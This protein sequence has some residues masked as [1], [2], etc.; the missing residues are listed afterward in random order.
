MCQRKL[1]FIIIFNVSYFLKAFIRYFFLYLYKKEYIL[2]N[3]LIIY[4]IVFINTYI[5]KIL[6]YF[7]YNYFNSNINQFI[8]KLCVQDNTFNKNKLILYFYNL[9]NYFKNHN[10]L[11]KLLN[12]NYYTYIIT[13]ILLQLHKYDLFY[14]V[15]ESFIKWV[16]LGSW[17]FFVSLFARKQYQEFKYKYDFNFKN[18]YKYRFKY[19]QSESYN[20]FWKA[21][22][23]YK[24]NYYNYKSHLYLKKFLALNQHLNQNVIGM[25]DFKLNK[26]ILKL[27]LYYNHLNMN[28]MYNYD[29]KKEDYTYML[30]NIFLKKKL[31]SPF[32]NETIP[33]TFYY[34]ANGIDKVKLE[35]LSYLMAFEYLYEY[36]FTKKRKSVLSNLTEVE[37][38]ENYKNFYKETIKKNFEND[39]MDVFNIEGSEPYIT[40]PRPYKKFENAIDYEN[41]FKDIN[42]FNIETLKDVILKSFKYIEE[43]EIMFSINSDLVKNLLKNQKEFD[44]LNLDKDININDYNEVKDDFN[45][46]VWLNKNALNDSSFNAFLMDLKYLSSNVTSNVLDVDLFSEP[47]LSDSNMLDLFIKKNFFYLDYFTISLNS[48]KYS[49]CYLLFVFKILKNIKNYELYYDKYYNENV[50]KYNNVIYEYHKYISSKL[51]LLSLN[52]NFYVKYKINNIY[53]NVNNFDSLNYIKK[54]KC[55]NFYNIY[56]PNY[57][58]RIKFT[59][60]SDLFLLYLQKYVSK[61]NFKKQILNTS[62]VITFD[63]FFYKDINIDDLLYSIQLKQKE[64]KDLMSIYVYIDNELLNFNDL[65][66]Y[67]YN[68]KGFEEYEKDVFL[69]F[70]L[71]EHKFLKFNIN[72]IDIYDKVRFQKNYSIL[73]FHYLIK[74]FKNLKHYTF[75]TAIETLLFNDNF[76]YSN[77]DQTMNEKRIDFIDHLESFLKVFKTTVSQKWIHTSDFINY[78]IYS[79]A[80]LKENND[81][82]NYSILYDEFILEKNNN[83]DLYQL[84]FRLDNIMQIWKHMLEKIEDSRKFYVYSINLLKIEKL[85]EFFDFPMFNKMKGFLLLKEAYLICLKEMIIEERA[86]DHAFNISMCLFRVFNQHNLFFKHQVLYKN[87]IMT[88]LT[89]LDIEDWNFILDIEKTN[90]LI[91]IELYNSKQKVTQSALWN[92]SLTMFDIVYSL[93]NIHEKESAY[94]KMEDD[95]NT[96][97]EKMIKRDLIIYDLTHT[98]IKKLNY[99]IECY[100][101]TSYNQLVAEDV[102]TIVLSKNNLIYDSTLNIFKKHINKDITD[103]IEENQTNIDEL[104]IKDIEKKTFID[105]DNYLK[106]KTTYIKHVNYINDFLLFNNVIDLDLKKLKFEIDF[107]FLKYLEYTINNFPKSRFKVYLLDLLFILKNEYNY[108][109]E[110]MYDSF[111]YL[112][113]LIKFYKHIENFNKIDFVEVNDVNKS[114]LNNNFNYLNNKFMNLNYVNFLSKYLNKK[115]LES[116]WS[117]VLSKTFNNTFLYIYYD[118]SNYL[119]KISSLLTNV[120]IL[121][122]FFNINE[123]EIYLPSL[124]NIIKNKNYN[125]N[126]IYNLYNMNYYEMLNTLFSSLSKHIVRVNNM[127]NQLNTFKEYIN[128]MYLNYFDTNKNNIQIL[129]DLYIL[130]NTN[131]KINLKNVSLI[132]LLLYVKDPIYLYNILTLDVSIYIENILILLNIIKNPDFDETLNAKFLKYIMYK[133]KDIS[134]YWTKPISYGGWSFDIYNAEKFFITIDEINNVNVNHFYSVNNIILLND[135]ISSLDQYEGY[136]CLENCISNNNLEFNILKMFNMDKLLMDFDFLFTVNNIKGLTFYCYNDLKSYADLNSIEFKY[137]ISSYNEFIRYILIENYRLKNFEKLQKKKKLDIKNIITTKDF[138]FLFEK[139]TKIENEKLKEKRKSSPSFFFKSQYKKNKLKYDKINNK[140]DIFIIN[141]EEFFNQLDFTVKKEDLDLQE[142][143]AKVV[144]EIHNN[145]R[146]WHSD[147]EFNQA[148]NKCKKA[149]DSVLYNFDHPI[150]DEHREMFAHKIIFLNYI[151][152]LNEEEKLSIFH[153]YWD[154]TVQEILKKRENLRNQQIANRWAFLLKHASEQTDI[155]EIRR[156]NEILNIFHTNLEKN[157]KWKKQWH[158]DLYFLNINKHKSKEANWKT[159]QFWKEMYDKEL[160]PLEKEELG[161]TEI[162]PYKKKD[163]EFELWDNTNWWK[164]W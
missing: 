140:K 21:Y 14:Y 70:E 36:A 122:K 30:F 59:C 55:K 19:K 106:N 76:I 94:N 35:K 69:F 47:Y 3:T 156:S 77:F 155:D 17:A 102:L 149:F 89:N 28:Y 92:D 126:V 141:E 87:G 63:E 38:F 24:G 113:Y 39:I 114:I 85:I 118:L 44:T 10:N 62:Q 133:Q 127:L 25:Y 43:S 51:N 90:P 33:F 16:G 105:V 109:N 162:N 58:N 160:D 124:K 46:F 74:L 158:K 27:N 110:K 150:W 123:N 100:N 13:S 32:L 115:Q 157:E 26:F 79:Y 104:L 103:I 132:N 1:N 139:N 154:W 129:K 61:D 45:L 57:K 71:K 41:I 9:Y 120:N 15:N 2:L 97:L 108:N 99:F 163:T 34:A 136:F 65:E 161:Y 50:I 86:L 119:L 101:K 49:L 138:E 91:I 151:N 73:Y 53:I 164:A 81:F 148:Y 84:E 159:Q 54:L 18:F 56:K 37:F 68:I 128:D 31:E 52:F 96:F 143:K 5:Y 66:F 145:Y 152:R 98:H 40:P 48:K 153:V 93:S 42:K 82:F 6:K 83:E 8:N 20:Y 117:N 78:I 137:N 142:I 125:K 4:F 147:L 131:K 60:N 67:L 12:I 23:K 7:N 121:N 95:W 116:D 75:N 72:D 130:I 107:N 22:Y 80:R 135:L 64:L 111:S 29:L 144:S 146:Q 134:E 112:F 11:D 88:R